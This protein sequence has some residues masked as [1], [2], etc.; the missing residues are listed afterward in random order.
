ML[1]SWQ[2]KVHCR[3]ESRAY[4]GLQTCQNYKLPCFHLDLPH[5]SECIAKADFFLVKILPWGRS[6]VCINCDEFS[7]AVTI[8][9]SCKSSSALSS[10]V[11]GV[12][13]VRQELARCSRAGEVAQSS[14]GPGHQPRNGNHHCIIQECT[15]VRVQVRA[16][17][18]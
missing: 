17:Q 1:A 3:G 6:M 4:P 18:Q 10:A 13:Y 2:V 9:H 14:A 7:D 16:G 8:Y 15:F 12:R 5:V 11:G